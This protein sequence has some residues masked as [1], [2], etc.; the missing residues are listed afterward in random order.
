MFTWGHV[1][2]ALSDVY[3]EVIADQRP[4]PSTGPARRRAKNEQAVEAAVP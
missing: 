2:N 4:R 1:A 3:D